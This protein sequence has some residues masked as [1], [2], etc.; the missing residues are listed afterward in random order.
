[1]R[2]EKIES[3]KEAKRMTFSQQNQTKQNKTKKT[4]Q[5]V[6]DCCPCFSLYVA[7]IRIY[8]CIYFFLV[9]YLS[10]QSDCE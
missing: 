8:D 5:T 2:I 10:P 3:E 7:M 6:L 4:E 1:M 9:F